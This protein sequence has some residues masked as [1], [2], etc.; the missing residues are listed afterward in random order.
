LT[1]QIRFLAFLFFFY[2]LDN[3]A[4]TLL[5]DFC[6]GFITGFICFGLFIAFFGELNT[7]KLAVAVVLFVQVKNGIGNLLFHY[8]VGIKNLNNIKLLYSMLFNF[9]KKA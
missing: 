6:N 3:P 4:D 2:S 8:S 7:D 5:A 9:F 1:E